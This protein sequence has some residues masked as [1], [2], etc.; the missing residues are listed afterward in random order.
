MIKLANPFIF[1]RAVKAGNINPMKE[2]FSEGEDELKKSLD[3][4]D[5][6]LANLCDQS[7]R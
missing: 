5:W 6:G 4:R 1:Y 7:S 2:E 3:S